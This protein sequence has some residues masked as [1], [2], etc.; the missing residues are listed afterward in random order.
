MGGE[1]DPRDGVVYECIH[2]VR[3]GEVQE[4]NGT[5]YARGYTSSPG[6]Y[7]FCAMFGD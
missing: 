4:R 7:L 2:S 1:G 5:N 6:K 3:R